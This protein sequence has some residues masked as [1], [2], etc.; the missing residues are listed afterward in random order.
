MKNVCF[1]FSFDFSFNHVERFTADV[2]IQ[3]Y[4]SIFSNTVSWSYF[5]WYWSR[6]VYNKIFYNNPHSKKII[7]IL[8]QSVVKEDSL[9]ET[10]P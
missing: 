5:V 8:Y 3:A 6:V 1:E 4:T 2:I 10:A 7:Y 9:K